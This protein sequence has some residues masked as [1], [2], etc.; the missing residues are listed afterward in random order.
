[1]KYFYPKNNQKYPLYSFITKYE[2]VGNNVVIYYANGETTSQEYSVHLIYSLER[3]MEY[4]VIDTTSITDKITHE[5][6]E[7]IKKY[8]FYL[9]HKEKL[10]NNNLFIND[11]DRFTIEDLKDFKIVKFTKKK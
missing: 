4:Q 3:I 10:N 1:M 7:E 5:Q 9:Q 11:L 6:L 8:K 2:I